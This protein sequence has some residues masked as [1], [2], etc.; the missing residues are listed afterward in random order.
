MSSVHV[1]A[2]GKCAGH[3]GACMPPVTLP[4]G[5]RTEGT[6]LSVPVKRLTRPSAYL[7]KLQKLKKTQRKQDDANVLEFKT[8]K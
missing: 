2:C 3:Q 6:L 5:K 7:R 8:H 1:C 4:P